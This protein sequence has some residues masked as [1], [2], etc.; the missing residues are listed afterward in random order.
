MASGKDPVTRPNGGSERTHQIEAEIDQTRAAMDRTVD[1]IAGKLTPQQLAVEA[2]SVFKDGSSALAT[3]VIQTAREHPLPAAIIGIGIGLLITESKKGSSSERGFEGDRGLDRGYDRGYGYDRQ[4]G[5]GSAQGRYETGRYETGRYATAGFDSTGY[6]TGPR[7]TS[8]SGEGVASGALHKVEGVAGSV[9]GSVSSAAGSVAGTVKDTA[10]GV[11]ETVAGVK[12]TVALGAMEAR[13]RVG[14]TASHV[15]EQAGQVT[16]QVREQAGHIREQVA[17]RAGAV[18]E[19][20]E[21]LRERMSEGAGRVREQA[22]RVPM[23]ARQ[24]WHDAKLG[25]W[26]TMDQR[27]F[28]IGIAAL[29]VGVAAGLSV[30]SSRKEQELMG[31][32]RDR[33][34]DQAK[35][36]T[37]EAVD[38]GKQVARAATD[39]VK[40]EVERQGLTPATIAEKV[41][42]IGREAEQALKSEAERVAPEPLKATGTMMGGGSGSNAGGAAGRGMSAGF[43]STQTGTRD[44]D[45]TVPGTTG[46]TGTTGTD[47]TNRT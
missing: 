43:A 9:A 4:V 32:T 3:K 33:L 34:L 16:E 27:P 38:M 11:K 20:A 12:D 23:Q 47:T 30:P 6:E 7:D 14:Q 19:T 39:T 46:T 1:L 31:E 24:Q 28:A 25:F 45:S 13:D 22:A 29:A 37:R 21:Q 35:G 42:T 44:A 17:D 2:M 41:R 10:A 5:F 8:R 36:Y 18:R 26:Q 40:S 15:R